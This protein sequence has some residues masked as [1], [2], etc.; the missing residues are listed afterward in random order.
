MTN[1]ERTIE[2]N[3]IDPERN[4]IDPEFSEEYWDVKFTSSEDGPP[5]DLDWGGI[6]NSGT[7][8]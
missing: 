7:G 4:E 3:E 8:S 1:G 2:E 6:E 5:S